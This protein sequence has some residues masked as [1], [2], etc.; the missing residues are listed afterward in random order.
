MGTL[1]F[2]PQ[3]GDTW[4]YALT[5]DVTAKREAS[6]L[7]R[8]QAQKLGLIQD[9]HVVNS[10]DFSVKVETVNPLKL[11][12][13]YGE[14]SPK[15]YIDDKPVEDSLFAA[16][17]NVKSK[18]L[19]LEFS[20][21]LQLINADYS[22]LT[23]ELSVYAQDLIGLER[24]FMD[25]P[26]RPVSKGSSWDGS[27]EKDLIPVGGLKSHVSIVNKKILKAF[28]KQ[29][30]SHYAE[31]EKRGIIS[32]SCAGL[33]NNILAVGSGKG[34]SVS[35]IKFDLKDGKILYAQETNSVKIVF[36][37]KKNI[38][39]NGKAVTVLQEKITL[40]YLN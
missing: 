37:L 15:I 36:D 40:Q 28:K 19:S 29:G 12:V 30:E 32:Q 7:A 1:V 39:A 24:F 20:P 16:L 3:P 5:S 31:V 35:R 2:A 33:E 21:A 22:Q 38:A 18:T 17:K 4:H 11:T 13:T 23:D 6:G 8:E 10:I 25:L 26:P 9:I 34:K 27:I 14:V